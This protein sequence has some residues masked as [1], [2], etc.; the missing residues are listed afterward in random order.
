MHCKHSYLPFFSSEI[1]IHTPV[2]Q[3]GWDCPRR[4]ILP[5]LPSSNKPPGLLG[6]LSDKMG[7]AASL[8]PIRSESILLLAPNLACWPKFLYCNL[9]Q[10]RSPFSACS[11][12]TGLALCNFFSNFWSVDETRHTVCRTRLKNLENPWGRTRTPAKHLLGFTPLRS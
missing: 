8:V 6:A 11:S 4:A 12:E 3:D 10:S 1:G 5:H 7:F 2:N 9:R